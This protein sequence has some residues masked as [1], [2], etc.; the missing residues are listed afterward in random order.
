MKQSRLAA[1][2]AVM[3]ALTFLRWWSPPAGRNEVVQAAERS[4]GLAAATIAPAASA[5]LPPGALASTDLAAGGREPES[6]EIR[7]AFA[8]RVVAP[9]PP[10]PAPPAPKV[11][12]VPV[13]VAPPPPPPPPPMDPTPP[14]PP[15][16]V[17]GA[18]KDARGASVFIAGPAGVVQVRAGDAVLAEYSVIQITA[19]EV[20]LRHLPTS[21]D[22]AL[23]IPAAAVPTLR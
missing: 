20:Q 14:P 17:I 11:A 8:A 1:L 16:Q 10:P 2:L 5:T 22:L 3:V 7:N 21:R 23:A 4:T 9:P 15:L 18:W 19:Q 12:V 6:S 13:V